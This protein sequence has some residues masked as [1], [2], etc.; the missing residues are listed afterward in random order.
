MFGRIRSRPALAA[1]GA[2]TMLFSASI[3]VPA[4]GGPAD[5]S[6][7]SL[8]KRVSSALK[9]AKSADKR[10]RSADKRS[11]QALRRTL[12][13]GPKGDT[14][15]AGPANPNADKLDGLDANGVARVAHVGVTGLALEGKS[16]TAVSTTIQAPATGFLLITASSDVQRALGGVNAVNCFISLDGTEV[17]SSERTIALDGSGTGVQGESDC[18]TSATVPVAAGTHTVALV[19]DLVA[20]GTLFDEADISALFVPFD[21]TGAPPTS[22]TITSAAK[23]NARALKQR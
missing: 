3:A 20:T 16:G 13:A 21:G 6:A 15:P 10:A 9:A 18:A 1:L 19:A 11:R 8:S 12:S 5:V 2:A 7:I 17:R 14:G 22:T 23:E 4:F